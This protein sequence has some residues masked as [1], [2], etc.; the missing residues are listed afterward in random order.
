[1]DWPR[2]RAG[3]TVSL[4]VIGSFM[5]Y[6]GAGSFRVIYGIS[7]QTVSSDYLILTESATM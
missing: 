2:T 4:E 7:W 1:M 6:P 3:Y 5:E